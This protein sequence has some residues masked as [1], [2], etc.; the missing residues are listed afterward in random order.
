MLGYSAG[1]GDVPVT[2]AGET[3]GA[4]VRKV[5]SAVVLNVGGV[6]LPR[7]GLARIS[8]AAA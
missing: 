2:I 4:S 8:L 1:V 3:V 5:T 6:I 7:I